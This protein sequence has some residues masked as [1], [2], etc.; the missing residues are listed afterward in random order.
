MFALDAHIFCKKN[1]I[2]IKK[3]ISLVT[4][5]GTIPE[6]FDVNPSITSIDLDHKNV[7]LQAAELLIKKLNGE[8]C[9]K[10]NIILLRTIGV[11]FSGD[12]KRSTQYVR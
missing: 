12:E 7:G 11:V 8:F 2:R 3:D 6:I 9:A 10:N 5:S 4:F 1:D